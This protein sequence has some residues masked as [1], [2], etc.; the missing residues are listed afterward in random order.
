MCK[1]D[2]ITFTKPEAP[3]VPRP[4][5]ERPLSSEETASFAVGDLF[6]EHGQPKARHENAPG[7]RLCGTCAWK[8]AGKGEWRCTLN[9]QF[10]ELAYK[11]PSPTPDFC[12]GFSQKPLRK[13]GTQ[14]GKKKGLPVPKSVKFLYFGRPNLGD[15][16]HR[17]PANIHCGVVTIAWTEVS[18]GTLH[19]GFSFCSPEDPWCK[20]KGR[21]M[22][23]ARLLKRMGPTIAVPFLYDAKR[24]V[25]EVVRAVLSHDFER[26]EAL[27]GPGTKA[28]GHSRVP[29][30]T[31]ALAKRMSPARA[32]YKL[33]GSSARIIANLRE[34]EIKHL[35]LGI[36]SRVMRDIAALGND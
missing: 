8:A 24:T 17:K 3:R 9:D 20:A 36:M 21:D 28:W 34:F 7:K 4:D 2:S 18:P 13:K 10:P 6:K 30:W 33:P 1:G 16:R 31:K 25:R 15:W 12:M 32:I 35:P 29:S 23:L 5:S 26:L 27:C 22:A 19:L 14:G 11:C